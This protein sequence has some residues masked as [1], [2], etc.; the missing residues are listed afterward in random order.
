MGA[1]DWASNSRIEKHLSMAGTLLNAGG[2]MESKIIPYRKRSFYI[3]NKLGLSRG[4]TQ[5]MFY[6]ENICSKYQTTNA[7]C[8]G[9]KV[10]KR[11]KK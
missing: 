9:E 4:K 11:S 10:K 8:Q 2:I 5:E 7:I 3:T 1:F 6:G